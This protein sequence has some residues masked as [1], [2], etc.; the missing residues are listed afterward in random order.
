MKIEYKGREIDLHVQRMQSD[1]WTW[2]Y[3][4]DQ[5]PLHQNMNELL[6]TE[7]DASNQALAHAKRTVDSAIYPSHR[8]SIDGIVG[9]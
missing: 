3:S 7:D 4:L 8:L 5:G 6:P 1:L 2:W 9:S